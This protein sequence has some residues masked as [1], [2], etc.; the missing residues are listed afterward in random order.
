[1]RDSKTI[2]VCATSLTN[3]SF[4]GSIVSGSAPV[5]VVSSPFGSALSVPPDGVVVPGVLVHAA[6]RSPAIMSRDRSDQRPLLRRMHCLLVYS[7]ASMLKLYAWDPLFGGRG[8]PG[9][10]SGPA[11]LR[12]F[13]ARLS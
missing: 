10:P 5:L 12:C 13:P 11:S 8:A 1:M 4:C 9:S 6:A 7:R 3:D 2:M